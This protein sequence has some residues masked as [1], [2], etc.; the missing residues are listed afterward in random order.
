MQAHS[1]AMYTTLFPDLGCHNIILGFTLIFEMDEETFICC[2]KN[3]KRE[4]ANQ[5]L[6]L[7]NEFQKTS[8]QI[9][10][11]FLKLINNYSNNFL[12]MKVSEFLTLYDGNYSIFL[13]KTTNLTS[14]IEADSYKKPS[15]SAL[16]ASSEK[17]ENCSELRQPVLSTPTANEKNDTTV[18]QPREIRS[19]EVGIYSKNGT[20]LINKNKKDESS[21]YFD[22]PINDNGKYELVKMVN[23]NKLCNF[24]DHPQFDQIEKFFKQFHFKP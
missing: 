3:L 1:H 4:V 5:I 17:E 20:P 14:D 6:E 24:K 10:A 19:R 9:D 15:I 16:P 13:E 23:P 22:V 21:M 8:N 11:E 7:K 12:D 2:S 18:K